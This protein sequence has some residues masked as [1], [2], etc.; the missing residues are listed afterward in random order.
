ML[1]PD[2]EFEHRHR[3]IDVLGENERE[4]VRR[5]QSVF[6]SRVLPLIYERMWRPMISRLFFGKGLKEAEERR[7]VLEMLGIS[8]GERVLD[9][10]CGTG[11]YARHLA[12]AAGDGLVVGIDASKPMVAAAARRGGGTNLAYFRGDACD[13][14]F[15]DG[16]FDAVCSVGV[17]HMIG[18]PMKAVA[19]MVRV[20]APGGR[21]V[22]VASCEQDAI[23]LAKGQMTTF[24]RDEL[25][26]VFR[27][28]GLCDIEQRVVQRGQFVAGRKPG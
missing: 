19:E 3:Y 10:G 16:R 4:G 2:T 28:E 20:L 22:I 23:P 5:D 24:G 25:T 7:I 21:L 9:S 12:K 1:R 27:D 14:P 13:L 15:S 6:R 26:G 11:N 8:P 17:I 18:E